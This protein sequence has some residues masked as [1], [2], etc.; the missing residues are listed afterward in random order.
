MMQQT[1]PEIIQTV[2]KG[3][4][5]RMANVMSQQFEN[6]GRRGGGRGD[7]QRDGPGDRAL[8]S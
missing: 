1:S 4:E 8:D 6:A 2:E 3:L 5:R 7:S